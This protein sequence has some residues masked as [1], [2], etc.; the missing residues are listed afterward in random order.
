MKDIED[1]YMVIFYPAA[2]GRPNDYVLYREGTRE[3]RLNPLLDDNKDGTITKGEAGVVVRK[4][5][6]EGLEKYKG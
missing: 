3:Y 5:L 6:K 1:V 4:F 2:V